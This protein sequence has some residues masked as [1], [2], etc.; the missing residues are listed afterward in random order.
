MTGARNDVAFSARQQ[1]AE[2]LA[3]EPATL[4]V[5]FAVQYQGWNVNVLES[6]QRQD[7]SHF[8]SGDRQIRGHVTPEHPRQQRVG[9]L[10]FGSEMGERVRGPCS[11]KCLDTLVAQYRGVLG[12]GY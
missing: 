2:R 8:R 7:L 11:A 5:K 10:I 12:Q 1:L 9:G 6:R 3:R 4:Q